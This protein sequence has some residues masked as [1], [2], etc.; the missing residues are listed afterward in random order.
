MKSRVTGILICLTAV[1]CF[2]IPVWGQDATEPA[3][4][5]PEIAP[6]EIAPPASAPPAP[7]PPAPAA[8]AAFAESS[9]IKIEDAAV[10]QEVVDREPVGISDLFAKEKFQLY[11][12]CRVVGAEPGTEI[13]H[14][15]Y[16]KG[17]LKASVK[18]NVR[19]SDYRTW[20]SKTILPQW[21]GEWMV[22]ILSEDGLPLESIIFSVQ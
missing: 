16:H 6:P 8:E 19:S 21:T 12:Y 4:A 22:E 2:A 13:T 10:C 7:A 18:L 20:S 1:I 9:G 17:N 5:P 15:W 14:N 3:P 11:C